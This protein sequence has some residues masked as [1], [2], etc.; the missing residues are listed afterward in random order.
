MQIFVKTLTSKRIT[1][2]VESSDM[3]DNVK[4]KIQDKE[5]DVVRCRSTAANIDA[6]GD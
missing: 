4:A 3:I 1:L 5:S 6:G 2:K